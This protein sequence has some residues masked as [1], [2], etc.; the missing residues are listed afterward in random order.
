MS[1]AKFFGYVVWTQLAVMAFRLMMDGEVAAKWAD[2]PSVSAVVFG[3]SPHG[4]ACYQW[5]RDKLGR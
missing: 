3:I 2:I 1:T 5:V 4:Q